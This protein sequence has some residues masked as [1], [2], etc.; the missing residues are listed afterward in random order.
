MP[1]CVFPALALG[2]RAIKAIR[3]CERVITSTYYLF[4]SILVLIAIP[5]FKCVSQ[6]IPLNTPVTTVIVY[7]PQGCSDDRSLSN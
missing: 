3:H 1:Y 6:C 5:L 2:T 4:C 7:L